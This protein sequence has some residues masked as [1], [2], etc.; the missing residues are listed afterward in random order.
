ML[1]MTQKSYLPHRGPFVFGRGFASGIPLKQFA[2][3]SRTVSWK[4]NEIKWC[5]GCFC[6]FLFVTEN[7]KTKSEC[8]LLYED[9]D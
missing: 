9:V 8:S 5:C 1:T 6:Q 4:Y 2:K 7:Y 3:T